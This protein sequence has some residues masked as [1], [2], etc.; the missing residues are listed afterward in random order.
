MKLVNLVAVLCAL[1]LLLVSAQA[2]YS[3]S[4][5][6]GGGGY[7][8][9]KKKGKG[10]KKKV[11]FLSRAVL[12]HYCSMKNLHALLIILH[13]GKD[14]NLCTRAKAAGAVDTTAADTTTPAAH[15]GEVTAGVADTAA[16]TAWTVASAADT[17]VVVGSFVSLCLIVFAD[18]HGTWW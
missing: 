9:G 8:K 14:T 17:A 2:G 15:T 7:G 5:S 16:D 1:A 6:Y 18:H 10:Y 12:S 4:S 3:S 11:L 13:R